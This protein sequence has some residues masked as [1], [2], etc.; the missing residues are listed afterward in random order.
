MCAFRYHLVCIALHASWVK[1]YILLSNNV[2][3]STSFNIVLE[4]LLCVYKPH[5]TPFNSRQCP[6]RSLNYVCNNIW[7]YRTWRPSQHWRL[8]PHCWILRS[9]VSWWGVHTQRQISLLQFRWSHIWWDRPL[10]SLDTRTSITIHMS[11]AVSKTN[12]GFKSLTQLY[13]SGTACIS[14]QRTRRSCWSKLWLRQDI[15][16]HW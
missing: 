9:D 16:Q 14:I 5:W 12:L 15:T 1:L 10:C 13:S 4:P 3:Q 7:S 8:L 6:I 2:G 11:Y